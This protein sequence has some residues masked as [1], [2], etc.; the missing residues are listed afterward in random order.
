MYISGYDSGHQATNPDTFGMVGRVMARYD[1]W[2]AGNR[3][4][5][6]VSVLPYDISA[7]DWRQRTE[8]KA[9]ALEGNRIFTVDLGAARV[10]AYDTATGALVSTFAAGPE[11][12]SYSGWVDAAYGIRAHQRPN[13]EY[14]VF[15]EE[16]SDAKVLM[17]RVPGP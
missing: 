11:V 12:G 4:P 6:W 3:T 2:G 13:G 16:D 17:Y 1:N 8:A 10:R 9:M 7:R 5:A 15:V 14:V